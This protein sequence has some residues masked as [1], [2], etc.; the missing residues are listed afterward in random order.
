VNI[1]D[2][3]MQQHRDESGNLQPDFDK[4]P[5]GIS[6]TAAYV[7]AKGL[8]LGIY[9]DAGTDTCAGYPGSLGHEGEDA[10]QFAS[11]GVDHLKYDN[12]SSNGG[13]TTADY[14]NRYSV[15]R[16]ALAA[17]GRPI[18]YSIGAW[19]LNAPWTW[20]GGIGN[21]WRTTGDIGPSFS[22]MLSIFHAKR[23]AGRLRQ[24]GGVERPGHARGRQRHVQHRGPGPVQPV[25]RD[26]RAAAG[27]QRPRQRERRNPFDPWQQ[28]GHRGRPGPVPLRNWVTGPDVRFCAMLVGPPEAG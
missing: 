25:G 8:K 15:M 19:G 5:D 2:R 27:R 24:T 28:V 11:W 4:F 17:T 20:G 12:C 13:S 22:S 26:G 23:R 16:D 7:H 6:G 3:W 9:A 18:V 21:L 10:R 14:V 1:D